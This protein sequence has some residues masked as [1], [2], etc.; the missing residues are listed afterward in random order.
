VHRAK[1]GLF[2]IERQ[3]RVAERAHNLSLDV[4]EIAL[5]GSVDTREL[6]DFLLGRHDDPLLAQQNLG[7]SCA[8]RQK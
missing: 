7:Q 6:V 4:P 3:V 1:V 2:K 8:P 5:L